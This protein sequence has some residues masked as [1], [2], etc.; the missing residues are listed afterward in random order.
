MKIK[1]WA[2]AE[3]YDSAI[4]VRLLTIN[5]WKNLIYFEFIQQYINFYKYYYFFS[6]LSC[7]H[8]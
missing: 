6:C 2:V 7:Q 4:G 3:N 8:W 5:C 1:Q